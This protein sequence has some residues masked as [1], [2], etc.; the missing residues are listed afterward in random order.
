[1][2]DMSI[3]YDFY[4]NSIL[5]INNKQGLS[6]ADQKVRAEPSRGRGRAGQGREIWKYEAP[7]RAENF[8]NVMGRARPDRE[9]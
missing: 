3:F 5:R 4:N 1:M 6:W 9:F 8:E 2:Y 7:G